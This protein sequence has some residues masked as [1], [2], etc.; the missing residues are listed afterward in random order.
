MCPPIAQKPNKKTPG[1]KQSGKRRAAKKNAQITTEEVPSAKKGSSVALTDP[2]LLK[3]QELV[4][5]KD[6]GRRTA[7]NDYKMLLL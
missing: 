1:S 7:T 5:K 2:L 6:T 4:S 3:T